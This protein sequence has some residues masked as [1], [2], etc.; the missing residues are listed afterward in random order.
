MLQ[1]LKRKDFGIVYLAAILILGIALLAP[2]VALAGNDGDPGDGSNGP[3]TFDTRGPIYLMDSMHPI[4][5]DADRH[6]SYPESKDG[7]NLK[8]SMIVIQL[9]G[10]VAVVPVFILVPSVQDWGDQ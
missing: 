9:P 5:Y 7:K 3:K 10:S 2:P 8:F 6:I 4:D 1:H